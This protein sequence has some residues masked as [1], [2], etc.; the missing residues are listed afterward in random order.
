MDEGIE[1]EKNEDQK[2]DEMA[3]DFFDFDADDL[4][5]KILEEVFLCT[6]CQKE[7]P[8]RDVDVLRITLS[9]QKKLIFYRKDLKSSVQLVERVISL[10]AL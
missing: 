8:K 5:I 7:I 1:N 9:I 2:E 10:N 4:G 3:A 6:N